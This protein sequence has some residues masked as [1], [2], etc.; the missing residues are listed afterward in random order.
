MAVEEEGLITM[1]NQGFMEFLMVLLL[2]A[3]I[4]GIGSALWGIFE[5]LN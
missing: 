3:V 1:R 5:H 2:L 4:A